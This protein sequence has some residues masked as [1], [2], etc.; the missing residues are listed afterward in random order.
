MARDH[1]RLLC[2]IWRDKDFKARTQAAQWM[3]MTL[4]SQPTI[5]NA[6][7]LPV[8]AGAWARL[9]EDVT[10]DAVRAALLELAEH[11]FIVVDDDTAELLVRSFMRN[12]GVS[13]NGKV[14]QN[15]LKVALQ[16]QSESLRR[17]LAD[18]LRRVGSASAIEAAEELEP[19]NVSAVQDG[20][21]IQI[22]RRSEKGGTVVSF[23]QKKNDRT[24]ESCGV[25]EGVGLGENLTLVSTSVLSNENVRPASKLSRQAIDQEFARFWAV[26]PRRDSKQ[27]ARDKFG[28]L[29]KQGTVSADRLVE[30]AARYAAYCSRTGRERDKT[31][32]PTT[33]LNQGCWDDEL[34]TAATPQVV[35]LADAVDWLR[36]QWETASIL[37]VCQWSGLRYETPDL[38]LG[39]S[40]RADVERFHLEHRRHWI[41]DNRELILARLRESA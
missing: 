19:E 32:L 41:E 33:W 40:G 20:S 34:D 5:S 29:L 17:V 38:P 11:R 31:K 3:Y 26:Y 13:K 15:A 14:F 1:A 18:E 8:T 2:R 16:V 22:D 24:Q 27:G 23:D 37:E 30:S 4:L 9:A 21:V 12:D 39:L 6:G 10:E 28:R 36:R 25:G 35:P 7:V